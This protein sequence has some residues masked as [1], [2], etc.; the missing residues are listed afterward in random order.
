MSNIQ[1]L[2]TER[3]EI[4]GSVEFSRLSAVTGVIK[5]GLKVNIFRENN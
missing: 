5:I 3:I 2:F 1:K 4:F